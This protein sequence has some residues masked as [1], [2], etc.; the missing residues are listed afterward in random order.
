[1]EQILDNRLNVQQPDDSI[2]PSVMS[3]PLEDF[4]LWLF[5]HPAGVGFVHHVLDRFADTMPQEKINEVF[6]FVESTTHE[7][8]VGME[9]WSSSHFQTPRGIFFSGAS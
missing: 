9:V 7:D 3:L 5:S 8:T 2:N 6:R 1:M 4:R